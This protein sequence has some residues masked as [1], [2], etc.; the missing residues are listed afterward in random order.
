[1]DL[2]TARRTEETAIALDQPRGVTWRAVLL[3]L[4][5]VVAFSFV[6]PYLQ[7][8]KDGP[9]LGLGPV[10]AASILALLLVL[11]PINGLLL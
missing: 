1:M 4:G 8:V 6:L 11:G 9:D 5:F 2:R 3:G 7:D 10:T